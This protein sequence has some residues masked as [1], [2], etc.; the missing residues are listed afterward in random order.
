M[1]YG[2]VLAAGRGERLWPLTSTRPKPLLPLPGYGSILARLLLQLRVAGVDGAAVVAGYMS[3]VLRE[4]LGWISGLMGV[5]VG[6][7]EQEYPRGTGD[8]VAA[9][10][11]GGVPR[12]AD[13]LLVV[14]GDLVVGG[15]ALRRV[16]DC[17]ADVCLL[18]VRVERPEMYGVVVA[19]ASGRVERIVE[20]PEKPPDNLVNAGVYVFERSVLEELLPELRPSPRGEYELTDVVNAAARRGLSV[21]VVEYDGLWIDVGSPWRYLEA[22]GVVLEEVVERVSPLVEGEVEPG[23]RLRGPVYVGR[24]SVVRSGTVVEGPAWITGDAGPLSHLRPFSVVLRSAHVG[25]LVQVKNSVVMEAAKVPHLNYV[26]DSVVGEFANLGAGTIT[27][28]LRFDGRNISMRIRGRLVDTGRRKLGAFIGGQA[29]TGVNVSLMPGVRVGAWSW[30]EPGLVVWRD[31][32]DC[33]F[34]RSS[35]V[36]GLEG[37]GVTCRPRQPPWE[38]P[39]PAL[40]ESPLSS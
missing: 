6:V 3:P 26:G 15:D 10:L 19:D 18:G 9:G 39:H 35:G 11:R 12:A 28:N 23:A 7:A 31:V 2:V 13:R 37:R 1:L 32:P 33:C 22:V 16:V 36:E 14:Y 8:A 21:R 38:Q 30:V 20:K 40:L 5:S 4:Y 17:E 24:E 27:A 34:A 25:A 29:E